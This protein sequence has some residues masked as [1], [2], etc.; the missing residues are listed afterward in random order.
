MI[1]SWSSENPWFIVALIIYLFLLA[2]CI[3]ALYIWPLGLLRA[4]LML[5]PYEVKIPYLGIKL[6]LRKFLVVGFFYDRPRVLDAWI[7]AHIGPVRRR[8]SEKET[9]N[10]RKVHIAM[11]VTIDGS[12]ITELTGKYL[13]PTFEKRIGCL[14]IWGEGGSG[15]TS[16]ACQVAKWA[17]AEEQGLR[18][19]KH[20]MLPV[21]IE[22]ELDSNVPDV[23]DSLTDAIRRQLQILC[24][25][26]VPISEELL[27][28]LLRKQRLLVIIDHFSEM[29]TATQAKVQPGATH[30]SSNA[31]IVTSRLNEE[32]KGVPKTV[33]KPLR[34]AGNRLSSFMENYLTQCK[35]RDLFTDEQFFDGCGKLSKMVGDREVTVLLAKLYAEQMILVREGKSGELPN[36]IPD[37][38]IHYLNEINRGVSEGKL[39]DSIVHRDASTIAWECLRENY[40]PTPARIT[41]ISAALGGNDTTSR[42]KY[43]E[44][45]LRLIQTIQPVKDR[46]RFLL[47]PLSEYLAG[48]HLI[49]INTNNEKKWREFLDRGTRIPGAPESIKGFLLAVRDCCI[50]RQAETEIPGFVVDELNV[51]VSSHGE[52]GA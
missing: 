24:D 21:L 46:I 34:I 13:K 22:E 12:I 17:M 9:V 8:F 29:S 2:A 20:Y 43:L 49:E 36:T 18:I 51:Q 31:L 37:L 38:M 28:H 33:I 30:F 26:S 35:K 11:P 19:S 42:L 47:D 15:K 44:D 40:R 3:L 5:S 16:L 6:P 39:E 4:N 23:A 1:A 52:K 10:Y 41:D 14:L 50:A 7:K 27:D 48:L 32:L 45:R 25:E